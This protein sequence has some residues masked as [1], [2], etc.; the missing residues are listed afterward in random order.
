MLIATFSGVRFICDGESQRVCRR[1]TAA[2]ARNLNALI[3]Q[4]V[5]DKLVVDGDVDR[6]LII[7]GRDGRECGTQFVS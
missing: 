6:R 2:F 4:Q 5:K 1:Y 3:D 7:V